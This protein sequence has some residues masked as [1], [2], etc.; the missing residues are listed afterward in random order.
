MKYVA[1]LDKK[2]K[3]AEKISTAFFTDGAAGE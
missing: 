3:I 1:Q 2:E